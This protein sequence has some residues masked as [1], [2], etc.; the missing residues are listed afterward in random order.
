MKMA[1]LQH[2]FLSILVV[3]AVIVVLLKNKPRKSKYNLPP[4]P[5]KLPI[6]RNPSARQLPYISLHHLARTYGP[7]IFLQLG[8]IPTV[9]VSSARMAK[10]VM[11]THDLALSSRP[12]IFSAKHLFYDCTDVVFSPYG[13]YWRHIR[14]NCILELI[15]A[16]RVQ[17][18]SHVRVEEVARLV[19]RITVFSRRHKSN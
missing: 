12:Q 5:P 15:S 17:S 14:R 19:D 2:L 4:S 1:L 10:K 3:A 7:I 8:E 9:V 16:K 6:L 13:P 18:Y 11:T